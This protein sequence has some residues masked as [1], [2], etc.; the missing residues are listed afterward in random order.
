MVRLCLEH[1]FHPVLD[2]LDSLVWDG[3]PRLDT[4][5]TTYLGAAEGCA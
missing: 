3:K 5:L 2:Y 1:A 4:W